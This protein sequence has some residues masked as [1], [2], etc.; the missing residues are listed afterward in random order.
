MIPDECQDRT[1]TYLNTSCDIMSWINDEM[2]RVDIDKS[3]TIALKDIYHLFKSNDRF[4]TFTKQDQRTY[5]QK[6]F[7]NL[8]K[9]SKQLRPFI[10]ERDMYHNKIR[11]TQDCLI[12]YKYINDETDNT[13]T[14]NL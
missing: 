8:L 12:G 11:A 4:K 1:T 2:V 9:S 14:D 13:N 5:S 6:Y 7:I 3:D 10:I